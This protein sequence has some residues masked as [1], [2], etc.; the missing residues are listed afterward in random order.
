MPWLLT[1]GVGIVVPLAAL[2]DVLHIPT[3]SFTHVGRSR[4]N[5]MIGL[6]AFPG[7][8]AAYW[9][10]AG[11][12]LVVG[13]FDQS[14]EPSGIA[15]HH[16]GAMLGRSMLAALAVA[17]V[18]SAQTGISAR[19]AAM[20]AVVMTIPVFLG[21]VI[22]DVGGVMLADERSRNARSMGRRDLRA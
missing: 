6:I 19:G 2:L 5:T 1:V 13:E 14:A 21:V 17:F 7:L 22:I 15:N 9:W 11:R 4:T 18:W 3:A 12:W 10:I 8:A 20:V 16:W